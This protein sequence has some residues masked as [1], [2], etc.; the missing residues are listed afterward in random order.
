MTKQIARLE[1]QGIRKVFKIEPRDFTT[2]LEEH[3]EVLGERLG[4]TLS[5]IEREKK[6]GDFS[7][8]L[9]CE[10]GSGHPVIIENQLER[11]DHDHLGKAL[12]YI[13]NL[14]AKTAIW[15]AGET[16]TEHHKVIDWLNENTPDD[17]SFYLIRVEAVRV[18][19]SLPAP[20]FTVVAKPTIEM[21]RIGN[22]KKEW[23][24]RHRLRYEFW[25]GLLALSKDRTSLFSGRAASRDHWLSTSIGR[26][27]FQLSYLI[28][29]KRHGLELYIDLGKDSDT[30]NKKAFDELIKS[31]SE[32]E[33]KLNSTLDWYRLDESRSCRIYWKLGNEGL[34]DKNE[35]PKMHDRMINAMVKFDKVF[36][37]L[38]KAV[39]L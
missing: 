12:T 32:I 8:D 28:H 14:G 6:T 15:V 16:R 29:M 1:F 2:W 33:D 13:V 3:I 19:D 9:L 10:D 22:E 4:L 11:T 39:K 18:G 7:C 24:E 31:R 17:I 25:A 5:V 34:L 37:P 27:G 38:V 36:K 26:S 35:W 30:L 23:A 20:L 21:K